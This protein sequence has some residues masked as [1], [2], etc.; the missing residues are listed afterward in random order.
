MRNDLRSRRRAAV[1]AV[2]LALLDSRRHDVLSMLASCEE[3]P[4]GI[5]LWPEIWR[6][7]DGIHIDRFV[8]TDQGNIRLDGVGPQIEQAVIH[9]TVIPDWIAYG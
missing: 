1:A 6:D 4:K 3:D 9:P 5:P 2:A 7:E 8:R